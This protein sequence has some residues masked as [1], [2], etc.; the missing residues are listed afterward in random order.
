MIELELLVVLSQKIMTH[1]R[2]KIAI[3]NVVLCE[4][5]LTNL[6]SVELENLTSELPLWSL[7]VY[8]RKFII[9]TY[10]HSNKHCGSHSNRCSTELINYCS[11]Q[12]SIL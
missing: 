5:Y 7:P 12:Y 1:F 8:G 4:L 6:L 2:N 10:H 9:T 3:I 11:Y